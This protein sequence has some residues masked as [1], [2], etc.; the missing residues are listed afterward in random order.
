MKSVGSLFRI[1]NL[2]H[3]LVDIQGHLFTVSSKRGL[4][5]FTEQEYEA[6]FEDLNISRAVVRMTLIALNK[7]S[8]IIEAAN[9]LGI[10]ERTIY[11]IKKDHNIVKSKSGYHLPINY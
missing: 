1:N 9:K 5:T 6:L 11:R 3:E 10:N 2:D 8:T 7:T 4:Q